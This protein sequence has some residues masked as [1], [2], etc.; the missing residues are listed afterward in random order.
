VL[1]GRRD[2]NDSKTCGVLPV[3]WFVF[4]LATPSQKFNAFSTLTLFRISF[5]TCRGMG[6]SDSGKSILYD[7]C[8][9]KMKPKSERFE[10]I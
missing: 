9:C 10:L 1:S 8:I 3:S 6:R 5:S 4:Y 2:F 7:K